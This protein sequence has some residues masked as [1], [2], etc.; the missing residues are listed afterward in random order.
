MLHASTYNTHTEEHAYVGHPTKF[1]QR[2]VL[3]LQ[4]QTLHK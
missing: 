3:P 2:K 1:D 4:L